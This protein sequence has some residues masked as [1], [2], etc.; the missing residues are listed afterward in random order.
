[1]KEKAIQ[2]IVLC[3][4]CFFYKEYETVNSD[5]NV[6]PSDSFE[7]FSKYKYLAK[8]HLLQKLP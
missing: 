4:N 2:G 1:M 8:I 3:L 5:A 6:Q 7:W